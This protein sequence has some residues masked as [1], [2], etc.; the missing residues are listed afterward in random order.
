VVETVSAMANADG[1][2]LVIGIEDDGT[3][4]GVPHAE[5]KISLFL[6]APLDRNYVQPPLRCRAEKVQTSDELLLLHFSVDWSP[7]VHRLADGRYLLRVNDANMPFPAEQIA[8]LKQTKAQGLYERSFPPYASF[9]DIDLNLMASLIQRM[10]A[11]A[12][13]EGV[14]RRYRLVEGRNSR[15]VPCLAALLLFGKDPFR[16]HPRCGID[17]IR[18]EGT[19]RRHGA[20]LNIVKRVR[21]E[22]PLAELPQR[23]FEA[24]NPHIRER[25]RLHGLFFTERLEYPSFVWQEAIVNAVAHRD[26]SIQGVSIEVWMFDDR[27]EVRALGFHPSQ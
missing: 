2:E 16:W 26:Y 27:I 24:I 7:E 9:D 17:F 11:D 14:L 10:Q 6:R 4:T 3:V 15:S 22:C 18:W 25:Q 8:A 19:E 21:I 13:P 20:E 23:A 5:D 1:G 12:T